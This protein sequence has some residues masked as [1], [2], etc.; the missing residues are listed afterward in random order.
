MAGSWWGGG[1]GGGEGVKDG[2]VAEEV[3]QPFCIHIYSDG[4]AKN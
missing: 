4:K 2:G 3:C 1:G